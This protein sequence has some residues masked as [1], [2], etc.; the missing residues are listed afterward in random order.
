MMMLKCFLILFVVLQVP[1]FSIRLVA[2]SHFTN[3]S[4]SHCAND[5]LLNDY[6]EDCVKRQ[7]I[8]S[9]SVGII[10]K[11][12]WIYQ[13][14]IR[15]ERQAMTMDTINAQFWPIGS[16]TKLFTAFAALEL[17]QS[18]ELNLDLPLSAYMPHIPETWAEITLRHLLS[19]TSG[20]SDYLSIGLLGYDWPEVFERIKSEP[21]AFAPGSSWAY[22]NTGYWLACLIIEQVSGKSY[23]SFLENETLNMGQNTKPRTLK[24]WKLLAYPVEGRDASNSVLVDNPFYSPA[25]RARGDG[26]LV[27]IFEDLVKGLMLVSERIFHTPQ[28]INHEMITPGVLKGNQIIQIDLPDQPDTSYGL[29]GFIADYKGTPVF[30]TPG[31][32]PGH[33]SSVIMLPHRDI[34]VIVLCN[35]GE[36]RLAD[37]IGFGLLEVW[38]NQ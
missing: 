3:N 11:G 12:D 29:G 1:F 34:M 17:V 27:F 19:H 33:S 38:L 30:W 10:Q 37:Q 20:I 24:E 13:Q 4:K 35:K 18:K 16:V 14:H 6:L 8:H 32:L 9:L 15:V 5:Q 31:A 36:F 26:D 7:G 22:S 2:Q 25:F 21:L 28:G 23:L